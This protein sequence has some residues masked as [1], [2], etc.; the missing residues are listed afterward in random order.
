MKQDL[1]LWFE[2]LRKTDIPSVGGKNAN[3]GEMTSA[4]IPVPP[5]FAITAYAY[6]KFIEY[7]RS[8]KANFVTTMQLVEM[9]EAMQPAGRPQAMAPAKGV[10]PSANESEVGVLGVCPTCDKTRSE[11]SSLITF[12]VQKSAGNCTAP[13]CNQTSANATKA[14]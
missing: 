4:G 8:K 12:K 7:A 14:A 13:P 2:E 9:V 11:A 5:G 3:L 1:V 10:S 6:K